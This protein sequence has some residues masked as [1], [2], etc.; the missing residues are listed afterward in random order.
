[1][2]I[3]N[4][5]FN[6]IKALNKSNKR[7]QDNM[8]DNKEKKH[9]INKNLIISDKINEEYKNDKKERVYFNDNSY[10][11]IHINYNEDI[12]TTIYIN[13]NESVDNLKLK[14]NKSINIPKEKQRLI[15]K[16]R[17]LDDNLRPIRS[18]IYD[19]N[20]KDAKLKELDL[21][22]YFGFRNDILIEIQIFL[23]K[24][25]KFSFSP[26]TTI[27]FV[28]KKIYEYTKIPPEIQNLFYLRQ[29]LD[30]NQ[31]L[32]SYN[33]KNISKL[34]LMLKSNKDICIIIK[35]PTGTIIP[36]D[37]NLN[38]TILDIKLL[39]ANKE[40]SA[41][42]NIVLRYDE[43]ELTDNNLKLK[44]LNIGP[45]SVIE[46]I[47]YSE[48]GFQIFIKTLAGITI[49]VPVKSDYTIE[50]IKEITYY[51]TSVPINQQRLI[52]EGKPLNNNRTLREYNIQKE[53]TLYQY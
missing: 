21:Y 43:K 9:E 53:S 18:Y 24:I 14:V 28:K 36:L 23:N 16:G 39:I 3:R 17:E 8:G 19:D 2:L 50:N 10:I 15:Y 1:M 4:R 40:K 34:F 5:F 52:F 37:V 47:F 33:M 31:M 41:L 44:Y 22:L 12:F 7:A 49:T 26:T 6:R 48:N 51:K 46:E 13:E 27:Y 42:K 25:L 38:Y 11:I 45:K 32:S 20:N 30:N 35:R 29:E